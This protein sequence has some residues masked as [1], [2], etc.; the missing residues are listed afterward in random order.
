L[1]KGLLT[2]ASI[3]YYFYY[4][5]NSEGALARGGKNMSGGLEDI[6][7]PVDSVKGINNREIQSKLI[8]KY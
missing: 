3:N 1:V 7:S 5:G 2:I 8:Q 4:G 6:I